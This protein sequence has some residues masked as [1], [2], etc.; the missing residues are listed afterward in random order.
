MWLVF[1][2]SEILPPLCKLPVNNSSLTAPLMYPSQHALFTTML[3]LRQVISVNTSTGCIFCFPK[4]VQSFLERLKRYRWILC[5][6]PCLFKLQDKLLKYCTLLCSVLRLVHQR[7]QGFSFNMHNSFFAHIKH[8][9][10]PDFSSLGS[11]FRSIPL[12]L[13]TAQQLHVNLDFETYN[14]HTTS[15]QPSYNLHTTFIQSISSSP[16][17]TAVNRENGQS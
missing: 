14:L 12:L 7:F 1:F 2:Q 13:S 3:T 10:R 9:L 16:C 15:I 11:C 8:P 17:N 5:V 4:H 6:H